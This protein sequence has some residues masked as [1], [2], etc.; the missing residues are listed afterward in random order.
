MKERKIWT[1]IYVLA[2]LSITCL[3]AASALAPAVL[4]AREGS[5]P[6][7]LSHLLSRDEFSFLGSAK[8]SLT[9]L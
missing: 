3:H 6:L 8:S 1:H 2:K 9:P 7:L 5:P 4:I